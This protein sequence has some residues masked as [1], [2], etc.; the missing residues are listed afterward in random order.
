MRVLLDHCVPRRLGPLLPGHEVATAHSQGWADVG[1]GDL[2][3]AAADAGFGAMVTMDRN[4]AFQ[5]NQGELP[6]PVIVMVAR[7]NRMVH[8]A[9]LVPAVLQVLAASPQRRVYLVT[10]P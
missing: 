4:L 10:S 9:P 6:L 1:N 5:Q 3:R 7:T 8:L 2:L